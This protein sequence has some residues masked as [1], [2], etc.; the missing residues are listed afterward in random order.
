[1]SDLEIGDWLVFS[2]MGAFAMTQ[3]E[4]NYSIQD[5]TGFASQNGALLVAENFW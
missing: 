5:G 2:N 4:N 1:M 3:W